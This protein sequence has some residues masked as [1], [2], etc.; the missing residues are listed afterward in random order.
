MINRREVVRGL[1][2]GIAAA[3]LGTSSLFANTADRGKVKVAIIGHT[4]RGNYG[5]GLDVC[6]RAMEDEAEIV[7]VAD[8]DDAGRAAA[9]TRLGAPKALADY[10]QLLD[11]TKP[12]IVSIC[13]RHP[14][15]HRDMFLAAAERGIHAYMEKPMCRTPAEADDMVAACEKHNV[16]LAIGHIT[17]NSP[18]LDV[19]LGLIRDGAIGD[20]LELRGRGK[21]DARRGGGEDLWV[22]GSHIM[23]LIHAIGGEP[24]WCFAPMEQDGHPVTKADVA[25]G[26]EGLGPLAGDTVHAVYG[27]DEGRTA[28]F[29]SVR[30]AGTGR[31][32]RFG[33]QILGSGGII[34]ILTGYLPQV[35]ILQDPAWS[36]GRSA[37]QWQPVSSAG[38]G[39]PEPIQ[40]DTRLLGN[41]TACRDL[42][43]AIRDDRQPVCDVYQGRCTVEMVNAVFDS[44]R[45]GG[46]VKFPLKTRENA[47][48][49]L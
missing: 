39:Q 12:D 9:K 3:S 5:H 48:G 36:P 15:Q 23:N 16:K 19:V 30:G 26:N 25:P 20:V 35:W 10:L 17:R 4:G 1:G 45:T 33:L 24:K 21:E 27:L 44:H 7:G 14:D 28:T 32:S 40:G 49:L 29:D 47:L 2:A 13:S 8:A 46:P 34:E 42:I 6:W 31:P 43:Q 37:K 38:I 22:L 18:K 41:I 11:E